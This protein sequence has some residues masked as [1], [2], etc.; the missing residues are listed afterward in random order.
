M[1]INTTNPFVNHSGES[2]VGL[3]DPARGDDNIGLMFK[4]GNF[5]TKLGQAPTKGWFWT[6]EKCNQVARDLG[7]RGASFHSNVAVMKHK[8]V[9][10]YEF[11][12]RRNI[13]VESSSSQ[14]GEFDAEL[15]T[16]N[17]LF[18]KSY[19]NYQEKLTD[20]VATEEDHDMYLITKQSLQQKLDETI[21][22]AKQSGFDPSQ[23]MEESEGLLISLSENEAFRAKIDSMSDHSTIVDSIDTFKKVYEFFNENAGKTAS[24]ETK[25]EFL[26]EAV[27]KLSDKL[28]T[29]SKEDQSKYTKDPF[30]TPLEALNFQRLLRAYSKP[31]NKEE[32]KKALLDYMFDV[33]TKE[34]PERLQ[35]AANFNPIQK[36]KLADAQ[37]Q[38]LEA[39][40][41]AEPGMI[42]K[43]FRN[44]LI[45]THEGYKALK[46]YFFGRMKTADEIISEA[47]GS[48]HD[49]IPNFYD[50]ELLSA[51]DP[52]LEALLLVG[53]SRER[54][55]ARI[56]ATKQLAI[57][58]FENIDSEYKSSLGESLSIK[59]RLMHSI[60]NPDPHVAQMHFES[61]VEDLSEKIY[62]KLARLAK[63]DTQ[64]PEGLP[65]T[66]L[67]KPWT[68]GVVNE[69]YEEAQ[70]LFEGRFSQADFEKALVTLVDKLEVAFKS[71]TGAEKALAYDEL[72]YI[73]SHLPTWSQTIK[74]A[75]GREETFIYRHPLLKNIN[76]TRPKVNQLIA[77]FEEWRGGNPISDVN[78]PSQNELERS[79]DTYAWLEDNKK[80]EY[81]EGINKHLPR[82][83]LDRGLHLFNLHTA[84]ENANEEES[85]YKQELRALK[86]DVEDAKR[87]WKQEQENYTPPS[88]FSRGTQDSLERTKR[89]YLEAEAQL[90]A[91]ENDRADPYKIARGVAEENFNRLIAGQIPDAEAAVAAEEEARAQAARAA[92]P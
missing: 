69:K 89:A 65:S 30:M 34:V 58:L 44:T 38:K 47:I 73:I 64:H 53:G 86:Q 40:K 71:G 68:D 45:L 87:A 84:L 23:V 3:F 67:L 36:Q 48:R 57:R 33:N 83:P 18:Q 92:R 78:P 72:K 41:R 20:G 79:L 50:D 75:S 24:K 42:K 51:D 12:Q 90:M 8:Q 27:F 32:F 39:M 91:Y 5:E 16:L 6:H 22:A 37:A 55:H 21:K 25:E 26:S 80:A 13:F 31:M 9:T 29:F 4:E 60:S 52:E 7:L 62:P 70:R 74:G 77:V 63:L 76:K 19:L 11:D 28:A 88:L 81:K 54:D 46:G 15:N 56:L 66:E 85:G 82:N 43:G 35:R 17:F 61:A 2:L 59:S 1:A 14:M 49:W 10:V